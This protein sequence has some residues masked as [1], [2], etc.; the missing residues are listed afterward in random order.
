MGMSTG[1]KRA[2][3]IAVVAIVI[4]G[5]GVGAYFLLQ[6]RAPTY[7]TPG[8]PAGVASDHIIKIGILD[9]MTVPLG[10]SC[11]NGAYLAILEIN[12]NGGVIINGSHYYFG[13]ISEDTHEADAQINLGTAQSAAE[14]I[15]TVDGAQFIMGGFR[16]EALSSYVEYIM[17]KHLLFLGTGAS[18]DFFCT[19]VL[20]LYSA[21]KYWFR[22]MP[23]NSTSLGY[24]SLYYLGYLRA[25]LSALTGKNI[26]HFAVLREDLAWTQPFD[27]AV[28]A[29][30]VSFG[31]DPAPA[32]D[33]AFPLTAGASEFATYWTQIA[34]SGAQVV[35]PVISGQAGIDMLKAYNA[36]RPN[37]FIAGID[38]QSQADSFWAQT[39][40]LCAYEVAQHTLTRTNKTSTSIAFWDHFKGNFTDSPIYTGAGAYDAVHVLYWAINKTQSLS[41]DVLIPALETIKSTSYT[42]AGNSIEGAAGRLWFT[43]S[44]DVYAGPGYL[45][46]HYTPTLMWGTA[47]WGQWNSSGY[48]NCLTSGGAGYSYS[49]Y[50]D[51]IVTGKLQL[52][53][54]FTG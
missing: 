26:T 9:P 31:W 27:D 50:P 49:T 6:P 8:M 37:C 53:P 44:H 42:S 39:S 14:K 20:N 16:T 18:T 2:L 4:V 25:Y 52:P 12:S 23:L 30:L 3:A 38:V 41:A 21:Y 10:I 17:E 33:I 22:L 35:I 45:G 13:L 29:N 51:S 48:K 43:R 15:V 7:E 46:A 40:G 54:W 19:K 36:S 28:K 1:T 11:H 34:A 24:Q 47:L 32:I 5:A